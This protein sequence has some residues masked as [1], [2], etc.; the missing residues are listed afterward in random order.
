M[1]NILTAVA[2]LS[3]AAV[4]AVAVAS[5]AAQEYKTAYTDGGSV[6]LAPQS[7]SV[8][9]DN[10]PWRQSNVSFS[11][12]ST[13]TGIKGRIGV[14]LSNVTTNA[15][16]TVSLKDSTGSWRYLQVYHR[17]DLP[18]GGATILPFQGNVSYETVTQGVDVHVVRGDSVSIPYS[19]GKNVT[20]GTLWFGAK[21]GLS[22]NG[23]AVPL[24]DVTSGITD[25][26]TG[27][28]LIKL[29]VSD[30][31]V[32]ARRYYAEVEMRR[33]GEVNTVLKFYLWI[34]QDVI[35]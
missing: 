35:R 23:Y 11:N 4:L 25:P 24:R 30:T 16:Y 10:A 19:I 26:S 32:S 21:A 34:D 27:T 17:N 15:T 5:A 8:T 12:L 33:P 2:V 18:A 3:L 29:S 9:K 13:L 28:G 1:K 20:G 22:D 14:T 31:T 7:Y 6:Y